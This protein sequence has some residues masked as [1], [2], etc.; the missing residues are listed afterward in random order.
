MEIWSCAGSVPIRSAS[1]L[2]Q[3]TSDL[4]TTQAPFVRLRGVRPSHGSVPQSSA[5]ESCS[6]SDT[7]LNYSLDV[8]AL[9]VDLGSFDTSFPP[10][11]STMRSP[12]SS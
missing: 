7:E 10:G 3:L 1:R 8:G 12:S 6:S 5:K 4:S 9:R 11:S 2:G